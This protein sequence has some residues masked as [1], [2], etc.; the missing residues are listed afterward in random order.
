[1]EDDRL[2]EPLEFHYHDWGEEQ[3]TISCQSPMP[4][5]LLTSG[6]MPA[7]TRNVGRIIW[8]GTETAEIWHGYMDGAVRSGHRA[9]L[10]ALQ[11]LSREMA[12]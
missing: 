4:R 3:Y 12:A 1:M 10:Q 5:G 9:A 11:T 6:L 8:S 2:L 7:L